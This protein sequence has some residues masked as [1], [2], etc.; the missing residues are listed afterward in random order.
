MPKAPINRI[1]LYYESH[2]D[3]SAP[4]IIFA[5][6][7]GGNHLSWWQQVAAFSGGFRCI[8]FDHRGWGASAA[9]HDSPLRE[10]FIDDLTALLDYLKIDKVFLVAQSMGGFSCLGFA[11]AHPERTLGLVLG[12]T[13]G[14]VATEGTLA[15]LKN[16]NPAPG[17]PARSLS[18]SFIRENPALT[19]LY[20]QIQGLNPP[21]GEDGVI[22]GFRREDGPQVEAFAHWTIPTLLIVGKEDAIFPPEV[23]AEVQKVIPGSSMEVVPGAAHSAH[24]EQADVFNTLLSELFAGVLSG[25]TEAAA[26][27]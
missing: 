24:F 19:F 3:E 21:R 6:G 12:D 7:R 9:E 4:A 1:D 25:S 18:A 20:Q 16:T 11:L 10:N 15:A 13:T 2:G 22:S 17:G 5:H 27:D 26:A 8:T 14:G 23:I